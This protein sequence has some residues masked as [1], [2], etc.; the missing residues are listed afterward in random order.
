MVNAVVDMMREALRRSKFVELLDI[1]FSFSLNFNVLNFFQEIPIVLI[2]ESDVFANKNFNSSLILF[3]FS[4]NAFTCFASYGFKG[5]QLNNKHMMT[6]GDCAQLHPLLV[7]LLN[8][9]KLTFPLIF[10]FIIL[11]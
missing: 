3:F 7:I 5:K 6:Y 4:L 11:F 10:N 9:S 1:R 8:R 2:H